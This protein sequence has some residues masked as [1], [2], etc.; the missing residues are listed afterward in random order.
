MTPKE[1]VKKAFERKPHDLTPV[2]VFLGGSWPVI[3]SGLTL[4]AL[5]GKARETAKIFFEVNELLNADLIMVG[6]GATALTIRALGGEI[7]FN[8]V[9]APE[10]TRELIEHESSLP[11]LW[12]MEFWNDQAVMWLVQTAKEVISMTQN[13]RMVLAS[14]RAP[15]TLATQMY[16]L[17]KT[18][19]AIYKNKVFIKELLEFTTHVSICY[20]KE[21]LGKGLVNGVF[22]ADPTA[23][24]DVISVK[25]FKEFVIPYLRK[26][27]KVVKDM[28]KPVMLHICGDITDRLA[29]IPDTGVDCISV[30]SKVDLKKALDIVGDK[31][32]I[33]GNVNPVD[34]LQFGTTEE[35]AK[36]SLDCQKQADGRNGF[37]LLPG[38]D[39]A[40]SV[41][42]EN[43]VAFVK[44]GHQLVL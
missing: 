4:D 43:I 17:E 37:V 33:A 1:R 16:G 28:G 13:Q 35:V 12:K 6:T 7:R 15:F 41:P 23:S 44:A 27:V 42:L 39:L 34:I 14:G 5:I 29:L 31:V 30:D 24:G 19:R 8:P 2:G 36:A 25:H 18:C 32:C 40:S 10:I 26:V 22:I 20:F 38:C 9:G 11:K 3:H 21:M